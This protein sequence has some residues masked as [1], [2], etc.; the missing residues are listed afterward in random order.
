MA[1]G[2]KG[3]TFYD[4]GP[5]LAALM[6][7]AGLAIEIRETGGSTDNVKLVEAGTV[8]LGLVNM[9]PAY[10]A[11][12]ASEPWVG[13]TKMRRLRALFPMYET[14]FHAAVP[15]A[16]GVTT[17]RGLD[18][19]R[20]GLGP[21]NGPAEAIFH[22]LF[23]GLAIKPA[24]AVG[25]PDAMARQVISG[26]LDGFA[27]GAGLPLPAFEEIAAAIPTRILGLTAEEAGVLRARFP[28]LAPYE[29]PAS[30]YRGQTQPLP[31]VAVWN[32]VL[33]DAELSDA[34]AYAIVKAVLDQPDKVAAIHPSARATVAR[35]ATADGFLPF[36]P[37]ARRYY[38][39]KGI[40]L[41]A[42]AAP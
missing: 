22:A 31:T 1:T 17:M 33:A 3:G 6:R 11:W 14:P 37:G 32:F 40:A 9:G 28:Y 16:G 12:N 24:M 5:G 23:M 30:S 2:A 4:Y 13:G 8:A 21:A 38:A 41:T 20:V 7:G 36:H 35:N 26:Q 10:E 18:G 27:Y 39:E 15:A 25:A 29:I 19:K 34:T 42:P